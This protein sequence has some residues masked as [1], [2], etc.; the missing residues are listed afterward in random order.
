MLRYPP[1]E[2][3]NY[4]RSN[5]D[6]GVIYNADCLDAI[7]TLP[8]N[9]IDCIITDP[10]YFL[11][12]THNG[13]KG[14]FR[15]LSICRPFYRELFQEYR[16]VCKPDACIYFFCD[17]R[18]YAFYYPLFDEILRA[19]NMLV[20]NKLSG[21]GNHYAF[22]HELVLF[23]AGTGAN[24]G[25]TNIITDVKSFTSGARSTDGAKVHPTQKPVALISKFI[26][27]STAPGAIILDTFGGSGST[28]VA[29]VRTGRRFVLMEQ[30]E[31]Y[32]LTAC[33]RIEDERRAAEA[34]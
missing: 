30:D 28:A 14:N 27:D 4:N 23:H 29:A 5:Y 1:Y 2:I 11:G 26:E 10:P 8:D 6:E 34:R 24:I 31:G 17:W 3:Q 32:Y 19:H 9:S 22:I 25:G 7:K 13:Q 20:W 15:D 18:G 33:K 12:M 21:P 16:R